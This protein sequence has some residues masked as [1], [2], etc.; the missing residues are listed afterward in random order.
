VAK[1]CRGSFEPRDDGPDPDVCIPC[2]CDSCLDAGTRMQEHLGACGKRIARCDAWLRR[3]ALKGSAADVAARNRAWSALVKEY[4]FRNLH[5]LFVLS[6]A[7]IISAG[8]PSVADEAM[9][10]LYRHH[11]FG[12]R[13]LLSIQ[14]S[15]L[16]PRERCSV[17]NGDPSAWRTLVLEIYRKHY[18]GLSAAREAN[19]GKLLTR[20]KLNVYDVAMKVIDRMKLA[21]RMTARW[22]R[23]GLPTPEMLA[24]V[25][26]LSKIVK[27]ERL[28]RSRKWLITVEKS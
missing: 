19:G 16:S 20:D 9:L 8:I 7:G 17:A 3:D 18:A 26:R 22:I 25:R 24:E 14:M 2:Q 11:V 27:E 28:G 15:M 5:V 6:A 21:D 13:K 1:P 10:R 4:D 12:D 23:K